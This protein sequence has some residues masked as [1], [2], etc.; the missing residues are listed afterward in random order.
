LNLTILNLEI[1]FF[2]RVIEC[3]VDINFKII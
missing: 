1:G 3:L 2:N